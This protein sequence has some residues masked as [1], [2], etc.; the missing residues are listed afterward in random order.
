MMP[1]PR[2]CTIPTTGPHAMI[3]QAISGCVPALDGARLRLRAPVLAD[4]GAY[5]RIMAADQGFMGGPFTEADAWTDFCNY[6]AGWMLHGHGLWTVELHD[7]TLLG[8]I[9][10]GFEWT[11][12]EPE[13]G[14]M[15]LPEFCGQ[16]YATEAAALARD[17]GL[18]RVD[19]LVSYADPENHASHAVAQRLGATRDLAEE[20]RIA[21]WDAEPPH[22]WRHK[23]Q[24]Q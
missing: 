20:S 12:E 22:V 11:D 7:G 23:G 5:A 15:L 14:W 6:I 24:G 13:L 1:V 19:S 4:F 2:P 21:E 10:L 9:N 18:S 3:A 17:W 16:G 8:F